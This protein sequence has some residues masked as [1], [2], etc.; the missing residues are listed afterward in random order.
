MILLLL[1][2]GWVVTWRGA[3]NHKQVNSRSGTKRENSKTRCEP[4]WQYDVL[5]I[6]SLL[7]YYRGCC[8]PLGLWISDRNL[9]LRCL[10]PGFTVLAHG[11]GVRP[12]LFYSTV[13]Y[14]ILFYCILLYSTLFYSILFYS[15]LFYSILFYSILLYSF[16]F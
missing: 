6:C 7:I 11:P 4:L 9:L 2:K 1:I 3:S 16:H 5:F 13:F 10:G 8:G 15:I 14:C 12:T